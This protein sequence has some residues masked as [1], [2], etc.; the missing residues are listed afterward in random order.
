MRSR[1]IAVVFFVVVGVVAGTANASGFFSDDDNSVHI[2]AIEAI[3]D[4]GITK[5]CNPPVNDLFCPQDT[6]TREQM[7]TFL[8]R[9]L[10][11]P[12]GSASFSDVGSSVHAANI[13]ALAT[14]G[15]T[16]GCNPPDNTLFCPQDTVTREQMATFLVRALGLPA[17]SASFSDVGSSV[18]A[19]N[20]GA[21]ATAGITK[22][23][24][25]PDN[26]LFCPTSPVTREQMATFLS[27]ALDLD[28]APRLVVTAAGDLVDVPLGTSE[29][30]TV[31]QLTAL[32]GTP[33]AD[34]V[35][36]CPY[37][38]PDPANMRYVRWGSLIVAI[39]TVVTGSEDLGLAG[40]RYKL[41]DFGQPE[42]G[43]PLAEHIEMPH[44]L[45]LGDPI[46]DA[47]AAGGG[48]VFTPSHG[49]WAV[50]EF[51]DFSVEASVEDA[52]A[53]IDGVQQG[54]GFDCGG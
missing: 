43:G 48:A 44:S 49:L 2:R 14:A 29:T 21:L 54:V 52:T 28:T 26:T 37:F 50:V 51:D 47:T 11:L 13:G 15:V 4:E 6:V 45:E 18:H 46:G 19:A 30:E 42:A 32:F 20:I 53:P 17:G 9:A 31:A 16:K 39:R 38:I 7:A 24:N 36:K 1:L 23:C 5:G 35:A 27:R 3:A 41:D 8:V 10:G 33:T 12:A 25:P 22:G 34:N 40:W